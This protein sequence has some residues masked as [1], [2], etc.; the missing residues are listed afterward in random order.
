MR[1][2]CLLESP[3]KISWKKWSVLLLRQRWNRLENV[4]QF[5]KE[6]AL[7]SITAAFVDK[8]VLTIFQDDGDNLFS[9]SMYFFY[10]FFFLM[11]TIGASSQ[12]QRFMNVKMGNITA[13]C[14]HWNTYAFKCMHIHFLSHTQMRI[15]FHSLLHSRMH[16]QTQRHSQPPYSWDG[17]VCGDWQLIHRSRSHHTYSNGALRKV[18]NLQSEIGTLLL[19]SGRRG[20]I[21]L[22]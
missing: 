8:I 20:A 9:C 10:F 16:T 7:L 18:K 6:T 4:T 15:V 12:E 17:W 14:S 3:L 19:D 1:P 21:I 13:L 2:L 5:E 11:E 22:S